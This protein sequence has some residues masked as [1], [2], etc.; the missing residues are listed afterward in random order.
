MKAKS[1][2]AGA[3]LVAGWMCTQ[4]CS[5]AVLLP[6]IFNSDIENWSDYTI[7]ASPNGNTP[8]PVTGVPEPATWAMMLLGFGGLGFAGYRR[9]RRSSNHFVDA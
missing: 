3:A 5:A 7:S 9:A 4:S 1:L 8:P 2:L 6:N